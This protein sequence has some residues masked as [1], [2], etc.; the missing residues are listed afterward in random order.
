MS[1]S[2]VPTVIGV[3]GSHGL[4]EPPSAQVNDPSWPMTGSPPS[5][6]SEA[7]GGPAAG[8]D[9]GAVAVGASSADADAIATGV[10]GD[11]EPIA[12]V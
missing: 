11:A 6:A 2:P 10:D 9:A 8:D 1:G 7:R 4:S 5:A 12:G 3:P